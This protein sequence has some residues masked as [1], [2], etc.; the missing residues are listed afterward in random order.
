MYEPPLKARILIAEDEAPLRNLMELSLR[1]IDY[2][3]VVVADGEA[4]L[5]AFR[6][7]SPFDMVV[8]D[9]MMPRV[10]GF[11]VL[12]EIRKSS[13]VPVVFLTAL[14]SGDD[15]VKGFQLGADD[16]ITKPFTFREVAARVEAILRRV[17]WMTQPDPAEKLLRN[18]DVELDV[19]FRYVTVR[20]NKCQVTPIEFELL[21][22]MMMHIDQPIGKEELF[23]EVWGYEFEGSTNLVEVGIRRLRS[24][25]EEDPS[26]PRYILTL[27]GVGYRF[28]R[29][30]APGAQ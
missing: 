9:I 19:E 13:A 23:R 5:D 17:E 1:A 20:G 3:V 26:D 27:R 6:N 10:N 28:Q 12:E 11:A 8:L 4:A 16:Y 21:R 30:R 22:Y 29:L 2:D 24:K 14:G 18:G 15:I 25:I 7:E